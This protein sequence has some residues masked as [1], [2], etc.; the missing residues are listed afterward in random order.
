[1]CGIV[2]VIGN[3]RLSRFHTSLFSQMLYA[4]ELRGHHA[5]GIISVD[6]DKSV[7][8]F[9]KAMPA[10]EFLNLRTTDRVI[11]EKRGIQALIGHNRYATQ[12]AI[13]DK[14]SHPFTHGE[15]TLVHNGSLLEMD[16]LPDNHLFDVDSEA[17]THSINKIGIEDTV[18]LL[19]GAFT[20]VYHDYSDNS[21]NI[22]RNKERPLAFGTIKFERNMAFASE[23]NMLNWIAGRTN[24]AMESIHSLEPGMLMKIKLDDKDITDFS[25]TP[26]KLYK[27]K[28]LFWGWPEN[29]RGKKQEKGK[30]EAATVSRIPNKRERKVSKVLES[31][32]I[33]MGER[34]KF[35][36]LQFNTY[37][38][39]SQMGKIEGFAL[40]PPYHSIVAHGVHE[41][42][43]QENS[44]YTGEVVFC[45]TEGGYEEGESG[46]IILHLKKLQLELGDTTPP[47]EI[48]E[49]EEEPMESNAPLFLRGFG[50]DLLTLKQFNGLTSYGCCQCSGN[51]QP[52]EHEEIHWVDTHTPMCSGCYD[53]WGNIGIIDKA[54]N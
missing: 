21:I 3:M 40:E 27:P 22:V 26:L 5:T 13:T 11:N 54:L 37:D 15:I 1:M 45:N 31:I 46:G 16:E 41:V 2:G 7:S 14:N 4:D 24:N 42:S 23:A 52:E 43:Y 33:E 20:L 49:E 6:K 17:I 30:G 36:A 48:E 19:N 53:S 44:E 35:T 47:F 9:K 10:S 50:K 29:A 38:Q 25:M 18:S 51:L 39:H 32:G 28:S 34:I 8:Y 12:G